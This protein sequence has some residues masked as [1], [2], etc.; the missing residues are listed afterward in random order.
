V[1]YAVT[2]D[3]EAIAGAMLDFLG[4]DRTEA[5][6]KNIKS[7]KVRFSWGKMVETIEKLDEE[8]VKNRLI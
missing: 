7:E 6:T 8:I 1:G 4:N 3:P 5:F 2:P